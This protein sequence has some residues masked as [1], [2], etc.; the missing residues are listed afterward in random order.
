MRIVTLNKRGTAHLAPGAGDTM[1]LRTLCGYEIQ[2][3][4]ALTYPP[5]GKLHLC[6]RCEQKVEARGY[7]NG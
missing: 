5:G 3:R 6:W 2:F 4:S 7:A 1:K